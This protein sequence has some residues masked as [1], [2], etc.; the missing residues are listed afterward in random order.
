[1]VRLSRMIKEITE[2]GASL[3]V[4]GPNPFQN[5]SKPSFFTS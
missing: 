4:A 2:C 3:I 5:A 1:M